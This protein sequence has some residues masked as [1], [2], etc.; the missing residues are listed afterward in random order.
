M[1]KGTKNNAAMSPSET[2]RT[3]YTRRVSSRKGLSEGAG[4]TDT[5]SLSG[6]TNFVNVSPT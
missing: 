1:E 5:L 2:Q 6:S 4:L 3:E